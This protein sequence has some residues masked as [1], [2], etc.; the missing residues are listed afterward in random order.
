MATDFQP[1][2]VLASGLYFQNRKME[3]VA[4][5]LANVNTAGFK[6]DLLSAMGYPVKD[7]RGELIRKPDSPALAS[8][9]FIYP[10]VGKRKI[11]LSGGPLIKTGNPLDVA[12]NGEGFFAVKVG[13]KVLYTRDGHFLIDKRGFLVNQNGYKVL[14]EN[15]PIYIGRKSITGIRVSKDG[16]IYAD[17]TKI[18]KLKIVNLRKIAKVGDNLFSGEP[19]KAENFAVVQGYLE[20]S[21]VNPVK[22]M[23]EMI[24]TVRVYESYTNAMKGIDENNSKL[25]NGILKA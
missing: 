1:L 15:G 14:G 22:E 13:N 7:T 3:T 25:I 21:N 17:G 2:Y 6:R 5:N 12:I 11:D 19:T 18:G 8:N 9:N 24:K 4:N 23:V 20:G 10:V 16:S